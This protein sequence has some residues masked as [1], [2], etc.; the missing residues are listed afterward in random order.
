MEKMRESH[1]EL[2][3]VPLL[4][5]TWGPMNLRYIAEVKGGT[6]RVIRMLHDSVKK[7]DFRQKALSPLKTGPPLWKYPATWLMSNSAGYWQSIMIPK[8]EDRVSRAEWK[9]VLALPAQKNKSGGGG[10]EDSAV[11][12][13]EVSAAPAA[14]KPN[15]QG[16]HK[17]PIA[18]KY[19]DGRPLR[20]GEVRASRNHKPK[21]LDGPIP[22]LELFYSRW[23]YGGCG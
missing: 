2:P 8:L 6:R 18:T 22:L 21:G 12:Q 7:I 15:A 3:T 16:A 10:M 5:R 4:V 20:G 19:P 13:E 23:M 11:V 1:P 17:P 14:W 9:A